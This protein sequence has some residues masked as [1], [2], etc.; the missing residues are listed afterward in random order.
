MDVL[1]AHKFKI[2]F[3]LGVVSTAGICIATPLLVSETQSPQIDAEGSSEEAVAPDLPQRVP[4]NPRPKPNIN[5]QGQGEESTY[6]KLMALKGKRESLSKRISERII[7]YRGFLKDVQFIAQMDKEWHNCKSKD[8]VDQGITE[9]E[10]GALKNSYEEVKRNFK[11]YEGIQRE[12]DGDLKSK[13]SYADEN[14]DDEGRYMEFE[15]KFNEINQK[16]QQIGEKRSDEKLAQN[17]KVIHDKL[18][19]ANGKCSF[20]DVIKMNDWLG[21]INDAAK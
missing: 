4:A 2:I 11:E 1:Q 19:L 12:I 21:K 6:A 17:Y 3:G 14:N 20:M 13:E 10:R 5:V 18:N 9:E 8:E 16:Y 7:V 15:N